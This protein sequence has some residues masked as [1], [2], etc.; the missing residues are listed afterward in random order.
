MTT[1]RDSNE[2]STTVS[3]D[4]GETRVGPVSAGETWSFSATGSWSKRFIRSGPNGYR[5]FL[6]DVFQ[7]APREP[8]E[9][10]LSLIGRLKDVP[11]STFP[12]GAGCTRTFASSGE[13]VVYAN[14]KP[15]G[16]RKNRGAVT[17]TSRRGGVAPGEAADPGGA[18]GWWDR[19]RDGIR[20]TAGIPLIAALVV[21]VS[22][23]LVFMRQGQDL[24]SG[25]GEDNFLQWPSDLLQIAFAIGLLFLALQAW[26]WSRVIIDSNYGTDRSKWRPQRLLIWTPRVL[27]AVPFVGAAASLM[28]NPASNSGFVVALVALGL[29]FFAFVIWRQDIRQRLERRGE[30]EPVSRF[31]RYWAAASLAGAVLAFIVVTIWPAE[32][33]LWIGA[34]AVVFLALGFIIPPA[35]IAI[36][37]GSSLQIPIVGALLAAAVFFGLWVDN[38]AVGRRAFGVATTGPTDR[39][40]LIDAYKTWK[41]E[42]TPGPDGKMTMVLVAVQGGAARAGYWTA[43]ALSSLRDAAKARGVDIDK[44]IFAISSVSGGSVGSV[45]YAALLKTAPNAPDFKL[46][47]LRF[48][49]EDALGP[50]LTGM[51]FPDLLQRFLPISFLPDRAES[52]ERSWENAWSTM[53]AAA[54][55]S[56]GSVSQMREPFLDLAPKAG[57]PWR[58]ILIVQGASENGGRRVLTSG[59]AFSRAEFDAGDFETDMG[60]DVAAS[61]AILNGARFP[62]ISPGGT[63]PTVN[64]RDHVLDGGYFDNAGAETLREMVR[65]LRV[66]TGDADKLHVVVVLIGY[67]NPT[68]EKPSPPIANDVLAPLFGLF[69]SLPAHEDHLARQMK[70]L[71]QPG[72]GQDD[73]YSSRFGL[74]EVDYAALVL[75]A[76]VVEQ[77]G[78][79]RDYEPPMDWSLSGEAK[80]YIEN[81]LDASTPACNAKE[82]LATIDAI[83]ATLAR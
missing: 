5:N 22:G 25:I 65:A 68:A 39:L 50:A 7:V 69:A 70:L 76:G 11:G 46:R 42:Q 4:R 54:S 18:I 10:W 53:A 55:D 77:G 16:Y 43:L 58:P 20:R 31:Q 3:C 6:A 64:G 19:V 24:V 38:H 79:L 9:P 40:S 33:G 49:G 73:P 66:E 15:D 52:L 2:R 67:R 48:A 36:Q 1:K 23:I 30:L 71:G 28:M 82:N 75:C 35:V 45:G 74:G 83:A 12:I 34:P 72:I 26:S 60:H 51:L 56:G 13:L 21:G 47:L 61:T 8:A 62:W 17:L 27:G 32:I 29:A 63:F 80:R 57:E 44:S 81:S 78:A 59:V 14:D 41:A 37:I